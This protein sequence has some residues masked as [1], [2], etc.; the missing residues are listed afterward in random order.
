MQ[1]HKSKKEKRKKIEQKKS[2]VD[3]S[4]PDS[5]EAPQVSKNPP[6]PIEPDGDMI[7]D[8]EMSEDIGPESEKRDI[9]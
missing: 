1:H 4:D 5:I 9:T 2:K 8:A 7:N 3:V 6:G